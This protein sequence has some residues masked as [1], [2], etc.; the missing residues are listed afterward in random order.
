[1]NETPEFRLVRPHAE[2]LEQYLELC[3]ES[4]GH[5]HAHVNY[6]LSGFPAFRHECTA[7]DL[8]DPAYYKK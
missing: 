3:G 6:I 8:T 4:G 5:G 2:L 7:V 1:M